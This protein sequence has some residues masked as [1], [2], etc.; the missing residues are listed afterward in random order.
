M[1]S[2]G[3]L[4]LLYLLNLIHVSSSLPARKDIFMGAPAPNKNCLLETDDDIVMDNT[5]R[6]ITMQQPEYHQGMGN[7]FI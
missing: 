7:T 4:A 5:N 1:H 2:T 3:A 6:E